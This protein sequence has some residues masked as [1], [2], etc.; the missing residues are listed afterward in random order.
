MNKSELISAVKA[1]AEFTNE[2]AYKAV[3]AVFAVIAEELERV[4][5]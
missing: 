1:K 2:Q 3:D 5:K 4:E